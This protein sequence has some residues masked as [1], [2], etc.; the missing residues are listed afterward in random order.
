MFFKKGMRGSTS[1]LVDYSFI[2]Q[3]S[4]YEKTISVQ[5]VN[6]TDPHPVLFQGFLTSVVAE[7]QNQTLKSLREVNVTGGFVI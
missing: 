5:K 2:S 4:L 7:I 6:S 1:A 3:K